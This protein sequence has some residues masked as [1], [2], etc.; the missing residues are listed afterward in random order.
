MI[1]IES[2]DYSQ[3]LDYLK[4]FE[5]STIK[6]GLERIKLLLDTLGNP[7]NKVSSV[8]IAGTNGKGSTA[9]FLDAALANNG[10]FIGRFVSPHLITPRERIVVDGKPITRQWFAASSS[11]LH[12][13]LCDIK[14]QPSYFEYMT[15]LA[16]HV[17]NF[18]NVDYSIIE[19]GLGGRLDSTNVFTPEV[20]VI[21]SV[22]VDH[23]AF[24]GNSIASIA[25]EKAGIIKTGV[26]VVTSAKGEALDVIALK[27]STLSCPFYSLDSQNWTVDDSEF[28]HVSIEM[29]G[30]KMEAVS[31]L[32]GKFQGENLAL[33]ML[34]YY[35]LTGKTD[36]NCEKVVWPARLEVINTKPEIILDGAHNPDAI[37]SLLENINPTNNDCLV[38]GCMKDKEVDIVFKK[39]EKKFENILLTSGN[40]HRFMNKDDFQAGCFS[41]YEFISLDKMSEKIKSFE[42]VFVTGSLH[43][44][45][46]F[47]KEMVKHDNFKGKILEKEPYN[48]IFDSTPY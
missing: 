11:Y 20:S 4:S 26:P 35:L 13:M 44:T 34:T 45:G 47:L 28:P 24:L 23:S 36:F 7:Q 42:K 10:S 17:F 30:K 8:H 15:A 25:S 6:L 9:V 48:F 38:F 40:Y 31:P 37:D 12:D 29:D 3:S 39:L 41:N 2:F 19:T 32:R 43:L 16:F 18:L 21:T 1:T 22:S 27:A 5:K 33:S 46:D 14:E